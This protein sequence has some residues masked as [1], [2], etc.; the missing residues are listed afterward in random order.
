MAARVLHQVGAAKQGESN[1][2][3]R[4]DLGQRA[5]QRS[6]KRMP[7]TLSKTSRMAANS[8]RPASRRTVPRTQSRSVWG[9]SRV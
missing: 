5:D 6:E 1:R 9:I 3:P 4:G 7:P 8:T 2:S